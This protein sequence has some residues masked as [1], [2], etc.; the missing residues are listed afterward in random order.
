MFTHPVGKLAERL[1]KLASPFRLKLVLEDAA[2]VQ[3]ENV[4]GSGLSWF[5]SEN[6]DPP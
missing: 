4:I 1:L 2:Y 5:R 3:G 6:P